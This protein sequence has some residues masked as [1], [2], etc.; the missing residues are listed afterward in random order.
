MRGRQVIRSKM[1]LRTSRNR[2]V[3]H[4]L[5]AVHPVKIEADDIS[6]LRRLLL[7]RLRFII[8]DSHFPPGTEH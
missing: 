4:M 3:G 8:L 1:T 5:N 2:R 7:A 6:Y